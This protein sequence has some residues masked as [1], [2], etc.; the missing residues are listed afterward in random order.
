MVLIPQTLKEHLQSGKVI[1]FVG[2]G[3]S[4][5]VR[6]A[7]GG[8]LLPSWKDLLL[9]AADRLQVEGKAAYST[10]VRSL[11]EI[12]PPDYL[13]AAQH[14]REQ[15][16]ENWIEYLR[17]RL[18]PPLDQVDHASLDLARAIWELGSRLIVTTNYDRVLHWSCPPPLQ[19]LLPRVP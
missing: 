15:L 8:R 7:E 18:D 13:Q 14:A 17:E 4:M 2:A 6:N 12:T 16:R 19:V 11:L 9:G 10:L 5:A 3:V 1:P